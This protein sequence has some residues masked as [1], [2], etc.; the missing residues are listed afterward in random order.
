[1]NK[2]QVAAIILGAGKGTRMNSDLPKVLMPVDGKP[3]IRH[4]L[5][6]LDKVGVEKIVT[7][8]APDGDLVKQE[9]APYP[10][11]VQEKQLGTGHAVLSARSELMG[12]RGD[13]LVIFGD[14]PIITKETYENIIAKRREGYA[15]VV[16]GFRPKDPARYGRLIKKGEELERIVEFK[17]ASNEE[18]AINLCNSGFM[19]FD[20]ETMFEILAAVSNENAAGEY[21]LTDAI[22]IA[23]RKGL[24]CSVVEGDPE[25]VASANTREE[26]ALLETFLKKRKGK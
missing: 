4:I 15:V 13:V 6:T 3:M 8:I 5:D 20:G 12:F 25:E 11:C 21:Y 16:L 2:S 9:V 10:I 18:K 22:E 19:C 17:D 23:R 14:T 24:K 1:M 7:V 26:L